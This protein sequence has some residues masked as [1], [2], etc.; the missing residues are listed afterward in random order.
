MGIMF[1]VVL[2]LIFVGCEHRF[3]V[4]QKEYRESV[5]RFCT[6]CGGVK[7]AFINKYGQEIA[8]VDGTAISQHFAIPPTNLVLGQC[9]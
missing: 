4:D 9:K 3:E 1:V 7:V 8:C 6:P 5:E 2:L